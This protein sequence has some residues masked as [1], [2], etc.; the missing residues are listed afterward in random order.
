M[1][2]EL[3]GVGNGERA[4]PFPDTPSPSRLEGLGER[5]E[6]PQ[7]QMGFGEFSLV[8]TCPITTI[9]TIVVYENSV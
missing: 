9:C 3:R 5:S 1:P 8:K 6:L 2:K 7:L 4:S